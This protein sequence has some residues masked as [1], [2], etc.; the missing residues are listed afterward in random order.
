MLLATCS[1]QGTSSAALQTVT[2]NGSLVRHELPLLLARTTASRGKPQRWTLNMASSAAMSSFFDSWHQRHRLKTRT[3]LP[4][5]F[6]CLRTSTGRTS[7]ALAAK[8]PSVR[9]RER[10]NRDQYQET[11]AKPGLL[12]KTLALCPVLAPCC[13][14]TQLRELA[15]CR[16]LLDVS[17]YV[18]IPPALHDQKPDTGK[19]VC[20]HLSY[21][22]LARDQCLSPDR[23]PS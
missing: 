13:R 16:G 23:T 8:E 7:A 10:V 22:E 9:E 11:V 12:L 18:H 15:Y 19:R 4:L 3:P 17:T 20:P 1:F 5:A 21:Q 14:K 2:S 6:T